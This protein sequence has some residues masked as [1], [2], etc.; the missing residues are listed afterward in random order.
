MRYPDLFQEIGQ[1]SNLY[2]VARRLK[3][4]KKETDSEALSFSEE[5]EDDATPAPEK[6][7]SADLL[8]ARAREVLEEFFKS[9]LRLESCETTRLHELAASIVENVLGDQ[10]ALPD[11]L[12]SRTD[13]SLFLRDFLSNQ[14]EELDI[15]EHSIDVTILTTRIGAQLGYG[16]SELKRLALT[17]LLHN[18]GMAFV[19]PRVI[20]K[21]G[22]LWPDEWESIRKHS[23]VGAKFVDELGFEYCDIAEVVSQV[24]ERENGQGYPK[25]LEGSEIHEDAKVI[26]IAD[27]FVALI[28]LRPFREA[29]EPLDALREIGQTMKGQFD[30]RMVKALW[31]INSVFLMGSF[32]MLSTDWIGKVVAANEKN[33][34]RPTV[35]LLI[36]AKGQ[37]VDPPR[38]MELDEY[39][40]VYIK[41]TISG[42]IAKRLLGLNK[43]EA[44]PGE[45]R[46][47]SLLTS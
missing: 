25:G 22:V 39:P 20:S 47:F 42:T 3:G 30:P 1:K 29:I 32:V 13:E 7:T 43:R 16:L 11:D 21:R 38:T 14:A 27:V 4:A 34:L 37:P 46:A 17:A 28:N 8:H 19:L 31:E 35:E 10:A 23:E 45:G 24:H 36:N 41:S 6:Q 40:L 9:T 44:A 2:S 15:V 26:A 5:G 12:S 18:V 33:P